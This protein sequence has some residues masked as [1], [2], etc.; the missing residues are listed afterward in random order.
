MLRSSYFGIRGKVD[1]LLEGEYIDE[2]NNLKYLVCVPF[3]LKTGKRV[4]DTHK[5]QIDL[6]TLLVREVYKMPVIGLLYYSEPDI[7]EYRS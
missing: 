3:E 6:Y 1:G 5:R 7:I 2:K 4:L